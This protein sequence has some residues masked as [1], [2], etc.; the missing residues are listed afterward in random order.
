M[1][2]SS[3]QTSLDR[4]RGLC[5]Q[6][7]FDSARG[8][9]AC[10]E[11]EEHES[12]GTREFWRDAAEVL[13]AAGLA[14]A[15]VRA[16][17]RACGLG[18]DAGAARVQAMVTWILDGRFGTAAEGLRGLWRLESRNPVVGNLLAIAL[19]E[20]GEVDEALDVWEAV[21]RVSP[22]VECPLS[23]HPLYLS[24]GAMAVENFLARSGCVAQAGPVE[25]PGAAAGKKP[26]AGALERAIEGARY[27]EV[28]DGLAQFTGEGEA[29]RFAFYAALACGGVGDWSGARDAIVRLL[30]QMPEDPFAQ[31]YYGYSL[32]RSGDVAM[33][34]TVLD[35]IVP[36]GPDDFFLNYNRG[37]GLLAQGDRYGALRAFRRGFEEYFYATYHMV[38]LPAW[39]SL[40][41][42]VRG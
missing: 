42:R 5:A 25:V 24:L 26:K 30:E 38:L 36:I 40:G 10:F 19:L 6:G 23:T 33:G 29:D 39:R 31:S 27:Q 11:A 9:L 16:W 35:M 2:T 17:E 4:A 15:S 22:Q 41:F 18:L 21:L 12:G 1:L 37:A 3:F 7:D 8:E 14:E 13:R 20:M 28:L 34:M 32:I